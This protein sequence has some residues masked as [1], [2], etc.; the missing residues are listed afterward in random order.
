M[1]AEQWARTAPAVRSRAAREVSRSESILAWT[2]VAAFHAALFWL[3]GKALMPRSAAVDAQALTLVWLPPAAE[4]APREDA[5]A[6]PAAARAPA[7]S[8]LARPPPPARL[9]VEAAVPADEADA[10][11]TAVDLG[12]APPAPV[13]PA[14]GPAARAPWDAPPSAPAKP[15]ASRVP[16]LP[17]QGAQRFRMRPPRSI[18][19]TVGQIGLLFGGGGPSDCEETRKNIRELAVLGAEAVA[20]EV[21]EERRNC[22]N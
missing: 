21:Q 17:G 6:Q 11:L 5:A 14:A 18:A 9:P 20:Q 12:A 4:P 15:F 13:A 8:A 10:G 2:A 19:S 16:V 1:Q 3:A 7:R 22:R